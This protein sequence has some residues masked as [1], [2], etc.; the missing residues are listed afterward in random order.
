MFNFR[1]NKLK[2]YLELKNNESIF[3][4]RKISQS[5]GEINFKISNSGYDYD[6]GL[7]VKQFLL[8]FVSG[9]RLNEGIIYSIG[10]KY[11]IK[12]L[13]IPYVYQKILRKNDIQI[14]TISCSLSFLVFTFLLW[15]YGVFYFIKTFYNGFRN[16]KNLS[17]E[18]YFYFDKI[19]RN[20][21]PSP[22]DDGK[23]YDLITWFINYF[24]IKDANIA[25]PVKNYVNNKYIGNNLYFKKEPFTIDINRTNFFKILFSSLKTILSSLI[26]FKWSNWMLL[27]EDIKVIFYNFSDNDKKNLTKYLVPNSIS[28]YRPIWTYYAEKNG[29]EV[30]SY[31]YSLS[32]EYT[33]EKNNFIHYNHL[34]LMNWPNIYVW[35]KY[36][37]DIILSRILHKCKIKIVGPIFFSTS[38]IDVEIKAKNIVSVFDI[39]P[40]A[41]DLVFG[42]S[43]LMDFDANNPEI[44]IKFLND[45]VK[46][47]G[48]NYK[49]FL[50]PKRNRDKKYE[51]KSYINYVKSLEKSKLIT[52]VDP[53]VSA[54]RLISKSDIVISYPFTSTSN[55][56]K[57]MGIKTAY[58][59]PT[60]KINK[61]DN[62]RHGINLIGNMKE[63]EKFFC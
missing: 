3:R 37:K 63:L 51:V 52:I 53:S 12:F 50:K 11:S 5:L 56:A 45:I 49:I 41:Q 40:T 6:R 39:D 36:Q 7:A 46:S 17:N 54:F 21:L 47:I 26:S 4:L 25:F 9:K 23:S 31:F 2:G 19:N 24:K 62:A 58:Y 13:P 42:M 60:G 55:I 38:D 34:R 27:M 61:N 32:E 35:D 20:N 43:T 18:K 28:F 1:K 59:D 8:N 44:H 57:S 16:K 48:K 15:I 22:Y 33:L 30:I 10:S 14:S 29:T